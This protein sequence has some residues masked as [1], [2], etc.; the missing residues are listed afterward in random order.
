M[1]PGDGTAYTSLIQEID[2]ARAFVVAAESAPTASV[3]H[4]VDDEPVRYR[5]LYGHIA[6][7]HGGPTPATGG[8]VVAASQRVSNRRLKDALGWRPLFPTYRSGIA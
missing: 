4:V 7:V 5:D 8:P 6:A 1:I 3:Y 2:A